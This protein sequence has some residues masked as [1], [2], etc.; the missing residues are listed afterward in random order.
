MKSG[1]ESEYLVNGS[2]S[3]LSPRKKRFSVGR[4]LKYFLFVPSLALVL[5]FSYYPAARSIEG[6][7]TSWNGFSA[8]IFVGFQNF[9]EYINGPTFPTELRNI[10]ILVLGG[11]VTSVIF[12]FIGAALVVGLQGR[13]QTV[14]KYL[15]VIPMVVPQVVL[16]D[17]WANMLNPNDGLVDT[18]LGL[19]H[20]QPVQWLSSTHTAL[21]SI[22]LIG[23]PWI[24]P[25]NQREK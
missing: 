2:L 15:I 3:A 16:I 25:A 10:S 24:S 13:I 6:S 7:F 9:Q 19:L 21:L 14:A 22:L 23:F 12:P 5:L 20:A 11:V 17:I 18:I 8:P 1:R 4:Y